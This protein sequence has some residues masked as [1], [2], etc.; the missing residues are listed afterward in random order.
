M[1]TMGSPEGK[2]RV[3]TATADMRERIRAGDFRPD[4]GTQGQLPTA[5][6]LGEHYGLSRVSM[7][8]VIKNLREE[9][10]VETRSGNRGAIV[11]PWTPVIFLPQQEFEA[12]AGHNADLLTQLVEAAARGGRSRIDSVTAEPADERIGAKLGLR[13]GE[14]VAVRRR[15]SIVDDVPTLTDDSYV[16]LRLVDGSDWMDPSNVARGTNQVLAE[17]GH[18]L[19]RAVD[20]LRPRYTT[21]EENVRLCL[22]PSGSVNAIELLTTGFTSEDLPVQVTVLTLP[23]PRNTVVYERRRPLAGAGE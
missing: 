6:A 23:G 16:P 5:N 1:T 12:S 3:E 19:D 13:P 8:N 4:D 10:L 22:S 17:L 18:R 7:N 15:T 21:A 11:R 20:E 14:H 9:G 2:W